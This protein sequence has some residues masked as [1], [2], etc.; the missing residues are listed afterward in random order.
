MVSVRADNEEVGD[1]VERGDVG[2]SDPDDDLELAAAICARARGRAQ[3]QPD[4][5]Q[6]ERAA[7]VC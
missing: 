1:V 2:G 5:N 4:V 6:Y 3:V 7:P